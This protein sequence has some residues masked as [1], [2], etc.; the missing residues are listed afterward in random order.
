MELT[1]QEVRELL[2]NISPDCS[3]DT[4][5]RVARAIYDALGE[6]GF[7]IFNE[8]SSKSKKGKYPGRNRCRYQ[9]EH[10]KR[11]I[12][13]TQGTLIHLGREGAPDDR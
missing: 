13:I 5:Y 8:W 2:E 3:N 10:S 7:D 12:K 6:E 1:N 11:L 9:W 4:W